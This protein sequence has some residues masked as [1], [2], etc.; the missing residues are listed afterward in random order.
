MTELGCSRSYLSW[1][2]PQLGVEAAEQAVGCQLANHLRWVVT[3]PR[4]MPLGSASW[5][6]AFPSRR[7][8]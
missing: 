3:S 5:Q 2:S 7:A 6:G 4:D 8:P 1:V